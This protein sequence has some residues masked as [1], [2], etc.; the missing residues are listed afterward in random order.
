[1][2]ISFPLRA[3]EGAHHPAD[4]DILGMKLGMNIAEIEAAIKASD[5]SLKTM[6]QKQ[7]LTGVNDGLANIPVVG[8]LARSSIQ[9]VGGPADC[10]SPSSRP[11]RARRTPST[12][13]RA[14][15][16]GSNHPWTR[17]C[18]S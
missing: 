5:P 2:N 18:N 9:T 7:P 1:M 12:A 3:A 17:R 13:T 14:F 8:K 16:P 4:F 15:P 10:T 11:N 6:V